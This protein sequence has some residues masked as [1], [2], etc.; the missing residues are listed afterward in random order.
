MEVHAPHE[1]IHT[2]REFWVHLGTITVGLLIALGLEQTV[3]FGHRVHERHALQRELH[4]EGE[5]DH[6]MLERD[7]ARLAALKVSLVAWHKK[8]DAAIARGGALD[9]EYQQ[10]DFGTIALPSEAMWDSAKASGRI[11][12]LS[13]DQTAAYAFLYLQEDWLKDQILAWSATITEKQE[14]ERRFE[15][16]FEEAGRDGVID[17]SRMSK[18]DLADYSAILNREIAQIDRLTEL[19]RYFDKV[20]RTVLERPRS[21]QEIVRRVDE[22]AQ[23]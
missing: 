8:V 5:H 11:G 19:L 18:E 2:W 14:F 3:E 15:K 16:S 12:L 4:D 17:Y 21:E 9:E 22:G 6:E 13:D 1:P 7:F 20:D 10:P 23:Q